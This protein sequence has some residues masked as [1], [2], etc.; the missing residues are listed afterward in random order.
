MMDVW[1]TEQAQKKGAFD[2]TLRPPLAPSEKN[3]SILARKPRTRE[4]SSRYNA[5]NALPSSMSTPV[6][7]RRWPSPNCSRTFPLSPGPSA[8]KRA[9]SAERRRPTMP[10]SLP[11]RPSTPV[12]D[13]PAEMP[14]ASR[15]LIGGRMPEGLWPSTRTLSVSFQSDTFSLPVFKKEKPTLKPLASTAH[16]QAE[17]PVVQRKSTTPERKRT[18]LQGRNALD[19][20]ENSKPM[21]NSLHRIVDQ[22]RWPSRTGAKVSANSLASSV[23]LTN[24]ATKGASLP[25]PGRGASPV[26]KTPASDDVS[27]SLR[28]S[29]GEAAKRA[30][31]DGNGR[32]EYGIGTIYSVDVDSLPTI[33]VPNFGSSAGVSL[34]S[35]GGTLAIP[36]PIRT[37]SLPTSGCHRP[38]SPIKS[39]P[40]PSSSRGMLSP[41]RM[42]P[43]ALFPL[44]STVISQSN[45]ISSV[46]SFIADVRK[47]K[48][49]ANLI[50]DAH[51]LRLLYNRYL[52]WRLV[53]AQTD[54]ALA[55]QNVMAEVGSMEFLNFWLDAFYFTI[56][57]YC[58]VWKIK[59]MPFMCG[60]LPVIKDY[61]KAL[62]FWYFI[63]LYPSD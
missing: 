48:K 26:R 24:R 29:M 2:E 35:S 14:A 44:A 12:L 43:S 8:S 38:P 7:P 58:S 18:P 5:A 22:H 50:E 41:L 33:G 3:N 36:R 34:S 11:S 17:S 51:Q 61:A 37:Q 21:E 1:K 13:V 15:R 55:I 40:T 53:N 30:S 4:V 39:T 45:S 47:G 52:Q 59:C 25:F 28:K 62:S 56:I 54:T 19:E 57:C 9:Q 42:R 32:T 23:D 20:S 46:L 27:R 60:Y 63:K 31:F 6:P 16:K 10:S 49:G